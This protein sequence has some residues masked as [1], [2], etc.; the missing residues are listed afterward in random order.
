MST[1]GDT[2]S[3]PRGDIMST[4]RGYPEY[5]R[6]SSVHWGISRVQQ[7]VF[8]TLGDYHEYTGGIPRCMWGFSYIGGGGGGECS[9]HQ[10]DTM[11]TPGDVGT[12]EG[13]PRPTFEDLCS[14]AF[15][16]F[17]F[18]VVYVGLWNI[19]QLVKISPSGS[20]SPDPNVFLVSS[21]IKSLVVSKCLVCMLLQDE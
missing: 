10:R 5:T 7:G 20:Q 19:R 14:R 17:A 18:A 21:L 12:N 15:A 2:I 1:V 4:V 11:S 3:T 6:G 16:T 9:V 13:K 8:S